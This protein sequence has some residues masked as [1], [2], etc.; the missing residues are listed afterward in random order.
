M[1]GQL[2]AEPLVVHAFEIDPAKLPG[3]YVVL[4][5][6]DLDRLR[7]ESLERLE[8]SWSVQIDASCARHR[9]LLIDGDA[10]GVLID[11]AQREKLI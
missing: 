8:G 10:A 4:P 3:G 11:A 2:N 6:G 1:A 5:Q 7:A 9:K